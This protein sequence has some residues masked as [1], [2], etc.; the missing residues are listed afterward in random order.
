M[1][2][3]RTPPNA[4]DQTDRGRRADAPP[5]RPVGDG[6]RRN[7]GLGKPGPP[8]PPAPP[9]AYGGYFDPASSYGAESS[10]RDEFGFDRQDARAMRQSGT[11]GRDVRA[12]LDTMRAEG[13]DRE[14]IGTART[15]LRDHRVTSD[16][17]GLARR[18]ANRTPWGGKPFQ[19]TDLGRAAERQ[20]PTTAI[21]NTLA[22]AHTA[23]GGTDY[24]RWLD[25]QQPQLMAGLQAAQSRNPLLEPRDY[26]KRVSGRDPAYWQNRY[27]SQ[28][29]LRNPGTAVTEY[30]QKI[31]ATGGTDFDLWF[32]SQAPQLMEEYEAARIRDPSLTMAAYLN[33]KGGSDAWQQKYQTETE[34]QNPTAAL[35]RYQGGL[36]A[37]GQT[38]FDQWFQR[39][40]APKLLQQFQAAQA[41]DP[42]LSPTA[43]MATKGD[44][45]AW[46]RQFAALPPELRGEQPGYVSNQ[47]RW[48]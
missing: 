8:T 31:G 27:Q 12:E 30:G 2:Q 39:T 23:T 24:D 14:A 25:E 22:P 3:R 48:V 4:Y 47:S 43:W 1:A 5:P 37:D 34:R 17:V 9:M 18:Q 35:T 21:T 16:E 29:Q 33:T 40:Q 36:G 10:Y 6:N 13:A 42:T 26:L 46:E 44:R 28:A 20:N 19:D 41:A 11:S 32:R 15:E 45:A 7:N 38:L